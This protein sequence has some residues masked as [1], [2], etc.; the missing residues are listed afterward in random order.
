MIAML[1]AAWNKMGQGR[2]INQTNLGIL[3]FITFHFQ[4]NRAY[5]KPPSAHSGVKSWQ[6]SFSYSFSMF[7]KCSLWMI[8]Q[9]CSTNTCDH[10]WNVANLIYLIW[11]SQG[12]DSECLRACS[13]AD[14]WPPWC[15]G[16]KR[17][18]T[19]ALPVFRQSFTGQYSA[20]PRGQVQRTKTH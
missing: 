16:R 19:A 9:W 8:M 6:Y 4:T 7:S 18:T 2:Q 5:G 3:H 1:W 15:S 17:E 20:R 13:Q 14:G 10:F 12:V 11:W